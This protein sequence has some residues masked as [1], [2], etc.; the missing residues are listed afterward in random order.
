MS[1]KETPVVE[2]AT[3][4]DAR[5]AHNKTYESRVYQPLNTA[6]QQIRVFVVE[7]GSEGAP[8]CGTFQVVSL[9]DDPK[10]LYETISYAWGSKN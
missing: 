5:R 9:E 7:P 3:E 4:Q 8:V 6:R 10:P 2:E 1:T